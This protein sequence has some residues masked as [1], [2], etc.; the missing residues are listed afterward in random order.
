MFHF[1]LKGLL[2]LI[3]IFYSFPN[4]QVGSGFAIIL[5]IARPDKSNE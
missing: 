3:L 4:H 1:L 5:R 2:I